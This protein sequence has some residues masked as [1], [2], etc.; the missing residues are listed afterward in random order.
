MV[1]GP[2]WPAVVHGR[3]SDAPWPSNACRPWKGSWAGG[4]GTRQR[5]PGRGLTG[6]RRV[7]DRPPNSP[8]VSWPTAESSM[9]L[10][11]SPTPSS[12]LVY[13]GSGPDPVSRPAWRW[14]PAEP[15]LQAGGAVGGDESGPPGAGS[16]SVPSR[17]AGRGPVRRF[18][19][20]VGPPGRA[21]DYVVGPCHRTTPRGAVGGPL[22]GEVGGS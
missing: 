8:L 1:A 18:G 2:T 16:R 21:V 13:F 17:A 7:V 20:P 3:R 15:V 4:A 11:P 12:N 6:G 14:L 9:H 10:F 22:G 5:P 19:P